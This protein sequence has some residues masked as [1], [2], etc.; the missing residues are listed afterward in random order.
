MRH[1]ITRYSQNPIGYA[2]FWKA[3]LAIRNRLLFQE[4]ESIRSYVFMYKRKRAQSDISQ[5]ICV[6]CKKANKYEAILVSG[7]MFLEDPVM[8]RH[9]CIPVERT[10]DKADKLSCEQVRGN[11]EATLHPTINHWL[12][13]FDKIEIMAW[14]GNA[15]KRN[16]VMAH[17]MKKMVM[18]ADD[19]LIIA[20]CFAFLFALVGDGIHTINPRSRRGAA[21]P[22]LYAVTKNKREEDYVTI[23]NKLKA[24]IEEAIEG[25]SLAQ[26]GS[27]VQSDEEATRR[28]RTSC[29]RAVQEVSNLLAEHLARRA[30][31]DDVQ[32][33][34]NIAENYHGRLRKILGKKH[35]PLAQLVL[36]FRS[37]AQLVLAF[38]SFTLLAKGTLARMLRRSE[39]KML[40]ERDRIR[41]EKV[42]GAMASFT[43]LRSENLLDTVTVEEFLRR[44]SKYTSDKAI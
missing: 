20:C 36:A 6:H 11:P 14:G 19:T 28:A 34:T 38:R 12:T 40:R 33:T 25:L 22:L 15:E 26:P 32:R 39:P 17:Y 16:A 24:A 10:K 4:S 9:T 27:A 37:F 42:K 35:P 31:Q 7:D 29:V 43:T 13:I 30:I 3:I 21:I 2:D 5:Y 18:K 41:W 1:L 23:F 8:L 44:M